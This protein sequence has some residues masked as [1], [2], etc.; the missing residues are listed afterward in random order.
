MVFSGFLL[1]LV[2]YNFIFV[3]FFYIFRVKICIYKKIKFNKIN[4]IFRVINIC[5]RSFCH[6][7]SFTKG[8]LYRQFK[9]VCSLLPLNNIKLLIYPSIVSFLF[10]SMTLHIFKFSKI[11]GYV[12]NFLKLLFFCFS[13]T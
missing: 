4:L 13:Q 9:T 1:L 5:V 6:V 2:H 10:C 3:T 12:S 7:D 8:I 11:S